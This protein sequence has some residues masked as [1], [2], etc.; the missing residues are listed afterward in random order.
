MCVDIG[1]VYVTH[2]TSSVPQVGIIGL[3]RFL[4]SGHPGRGGP[5][6]PSCGQRVGVWG[7]GFRVSV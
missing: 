4:A 7:G 3:L 6:R 2:G 1:L 5:C